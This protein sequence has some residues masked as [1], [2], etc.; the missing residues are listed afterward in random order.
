MDYT[1]SVDYNH[2]NQLDREN[3]CMTIVS[4]FP[5]INISYIFHSDTHVLFKAPS[6]NQNCPQV[7]FGLSYFYCYIE[8]SKLFS[9]KRSDQLGQLGPKSIS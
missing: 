7:M 3:I 2:N 4:Y 6:P 1:H 9:S 8:K 5:T